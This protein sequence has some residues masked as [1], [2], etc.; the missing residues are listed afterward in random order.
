LW[1]DEN[2]HKYISDRVYLLLISTLH[3]GSDA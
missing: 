3:G 2:K 1:P